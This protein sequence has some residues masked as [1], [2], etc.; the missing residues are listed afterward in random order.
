MAIIANFLASILMLLLA[1]PAAVA[2]ATPSARAAPPT[3]RATPAAAQAAPQVASVL[4]VRVVNLRNSTG[5]VICTLWNSPLA[6]PTDSSRAL[7]QIAVPIKDNAAVC[8]FGGLAPGK[9]ALVAFHDENSNGKFDRNWLGL[10]KEGYAFS[11]NVRP[12][13][14]PP[15]FRAAAFDYGGGDQWL[16]LAM[17]Y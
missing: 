9:Y 16:T 11:N 6:F 7:G 4:H 14:S 12:V 2:V 1:A 8:N 15:S 10:P 3:A 17:H 5:Q 13:F